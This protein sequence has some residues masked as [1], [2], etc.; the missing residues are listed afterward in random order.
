MLTPISFVFYL[1]N[2]FFGLQ[3]PVVREDRHFILQQRYKYPPRIVIDI[4]IKNI[5]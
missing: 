1:I 4:L 3:L 5:P 2:L